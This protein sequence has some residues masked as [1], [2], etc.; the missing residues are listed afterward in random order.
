[1]DVVC[2]GCGD[3]LSLKPKERRILG[4]ES[5]KPVLEVW[6]A[7][8]IQEVDDEEIED[9]DQVVESVINDHQI[10]R[11]CFYANKRFLKLQRSLEDN[12][13]DTE[14]RVEDI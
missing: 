2:V 4:S 11:K 9:V 8:Y 3:D 1:M 14:T 13:S 12:L 5:L 6:K 7:L 10:F